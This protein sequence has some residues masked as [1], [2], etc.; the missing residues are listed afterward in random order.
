MELIDKKTIQ[1]VAKLS[2][3]EIRDNEMESFGQNFNK[4]IGFFENLT[5]LKTDNVQPTTHPVENENIF[6]E[7][8]VLESMSN[9]ELSK[10]APE[11]DQ[12]SIVVPKIIE[13]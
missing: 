2:K 3:L 13:S 9:E 1:N 11:F 12:G 4:I 6:R 10:L 7:D 8:K 5:K